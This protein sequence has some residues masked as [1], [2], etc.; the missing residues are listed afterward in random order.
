IVER[1]PPYLKPGGTLIME[2]S[3]EQADRITGLIES[4]GSFQRVSILRDLSQCARA[5]RAQ[6]RTNDA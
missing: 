1:A 3:P 2:F 6:K 5:V 4:S